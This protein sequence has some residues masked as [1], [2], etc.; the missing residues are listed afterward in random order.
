MIN[1]T[2]FTGPA[3]EIPWDFP[4]EAMRHKTYDAF[5]QERSALENLGKIKVP[6][7]SIGIWSKVN[8][9]LQGNIIGFQRASGPKKLLVTGAPDVFAAVA[10]FASTDFH[11]KYLLPFYDWCLK[12]QQTSY[13]SEPDVRYAILG[14]NQMKSS[15]DWPPTKS[16]SYTPY[17]LSSEHSGSVT[18]LND[19]TI[20]TAP[21]NG[22]SE[23]SYSYPDQAWRVGVVGTSNGRPD[24][25]GRVLTFT[26]A[27]LTEDLEIA[28]P[29][30]VVLYAA[31]TQK[32]TDFIVKLS[33]Q[34]PQS[35]E[36]RGRGIQPAA[37]NASKGWLRASYRELDPK[38]ST[39]DV[40]WYQSVSPQPLTPGQ[41]YK[42]EIA[43]MPTAYLFKK[44][45]RIRLEI[46]NG[47]SALTDFVFTHAYEPNKVG[48]DTIY[49]DARYPSLLL[50]P[51]VN[52]NS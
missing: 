28:G 8:L 33:E 5:W 39:D 19:G 47:D 25:I 51:V 10:D 4:R 40:P 22:A 46:A 26:S 17:Y 21:P 20:A 37:R 32:D 18:S 31:S 42:F 38:N 34:M 16:I 50:L 23:T 11:Q 2:P 29:I 52:P 14:T 12:G 7:F 35:S 48:R 13:V 41:I 27:P 45:S 24:L 43:V 6:L 9:H 30:K 36:D 44:G 49:H 1:D 3:H 15:A